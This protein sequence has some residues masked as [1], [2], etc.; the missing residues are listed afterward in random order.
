MTEFL[1]GF[2]VGHYTDEANRTG[3]TVV[4]PPAG[5]VT[6]CDVRGS[7]PA[8]RELVL[9]DLDRR[10]TEVHAVLLTGGSAFGLAAADGVMTWLAEH[11]VGYHTLVARVPI[12][13]AA[14]IFDLGAGNANARPGPSEGR[15]ACEAASS[16]GI[17]TGPVGAGTG[18]TVGKWS[19]LEKAARGGFGI[20]HATAEGNR[21]AAL[22]V[23]NAVGDVVSSDGSSLAGSSV[24]EGRLHGPRPPATEVAPINT[25]L[26]LVATRAALDKREVK[27]LAGRGSD[28]IT[29]SVRPAHTRYDGDVC[30]AIA[31]PP[32]EGAAE[33]NLDVLGVLATE[34]VASAVR[35]AVEAE[36]A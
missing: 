21:V 18:A 30:F 34:A 16:S 10:L 7:S 27:W 19:G 6:S 5:N 20:A 9:L 14:V 2:R 29:T 13:P 12:V 22:A 32:A 11:D 36:P 8:S 25:V 24:E 1:E 23:V 26:A 15:A 33:T 35:N 28:G 4:L 17:A 31:G 3:C